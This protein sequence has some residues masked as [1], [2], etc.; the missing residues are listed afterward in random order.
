[1]LVVGRFFLPFPV[2]LLQWTKKKPKFL[3]MV[4]VWILLMQLLDVYV[5]VLPVFHP[6][7]FSLSP[8]DLSAVL[9]IGGILGW[10][11]FRNLGQSHLFPLRDPR[12]GG[13]LKLTN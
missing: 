1:L 10:L 13:S 11:F 5:I 7:G 4:A 2:L 3:C 6:G 12:L 9:G 8:F